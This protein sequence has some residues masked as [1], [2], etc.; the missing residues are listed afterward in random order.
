MNHNALRELTEAAD[1]LAAAG[2]TIPD[3]YTRIHDRWNS[4]CELTYNH[5]TRLAAAVT[6]PDDP[7]DLD[8]LRALALAERAGARDEADLDTDIRAAV[9]LALAEA[10]EP[11]AAQNYKTIAAR[12]DTLATAFTK[13]AAQ[14]DPEA[15]AE[16]MVTAGDKA[17]KAWTDVQLH[18]HELDTHLHLLRMAAQLAGQRITPP[19]GLLALTCDTTGHHRRRVWEAWDTTTG[20]TT[21]WGA[22]HAAGVTIRAV[23]LDE[24]EHYRR[25]APMEVRYVRDSHGHRPVQHD[26]EDELV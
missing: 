13:A 19:D 2:A 16:Q 9:Y 26:P 11:V 18:T 12:F 17:R 10:Y 22:L 8:T 15:P 20:R 5:T 23:D 7:A 14:C 3:T 6:N 21:R 24:Y 25:P 4:Y 1:T